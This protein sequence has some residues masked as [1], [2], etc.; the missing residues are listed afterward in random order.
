MLLLKDFHHVLEVLMHQGR[1]FSFS[2]IYL[3]VDNLRPGSYETD[4]KQNR[5][6]Q[7]LHSFGG[8][9]KLV[10]PVKTKC[11]PLNNDKVWQ[12]TIL[13]FSLYIFTI[14]L[15]CLICEKTPVGDYYQYHKEILCSS[16]F[17]FN[18]QWQEK[19]K[20]T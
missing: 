20:R 17:N 13:F 12:M 19:F 4:V 6:V 2:L 1:T 3:N 9:T 16:C 7:M 14:I 18:W 8:R 10:P 15:Q 5:Q 11:M